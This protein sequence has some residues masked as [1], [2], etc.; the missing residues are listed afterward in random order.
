MISLSIMWKSR[1]TGEGIFL[2]F[3]KPCF[4][5]RLRILLLSTEYISNRSISVN[6]R[7]YMSM[8]ISRSVFMTLYTCKCAH[9]ENN[10][11]SINYFMYISDL[12]A[13]SERYWCCSL[14]NKWAI[15]S[16]K[17]S[18]FLMHRARIWGIRSMIDQ[19]SAPCFIKIDVQRKLTQDII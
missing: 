2:F 5:S 15:R 18:L 19:T 13:V 14:Q 11:A 4:L 8:R 7:L 9:R 16:P 17:D 3:P 1:P 12:C 10:T 6:M